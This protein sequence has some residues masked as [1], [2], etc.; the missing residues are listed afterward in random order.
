MSRI[1]K[2]PLQFGPNGG[3]VRLTPVK[4]GR[5]GFD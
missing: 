5:F 2:S 4:R 3:M 1:Y